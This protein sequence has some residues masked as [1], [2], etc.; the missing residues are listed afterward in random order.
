MAQSSWQPL[1]IGNVVTTAFQLYKNR[2]QPYFALAFKAYFWLLVPV[3]GWAKFLAIS[4]LI[5]RLVYGELVNQPETITG[6]TKY[7]NSKLWQFLIASVLF[8]LIVLS[9]WIALVIVSVIILTIVFLVIMGSVSSLQP[10]NITNTIIVA[11][12]FSISTIGS[13][14]FLIR[15]FVL[16]LPLAIEDNINATST[17]RRSWKLIKNFESHTL[18]ISLVAFLIT[19]PLLALLEIICYLIFRF[20]F[21]SW[22]IANPLIAL[23]ALVE[24]IRKMFQLLFDGSTNQKQIFNLLFWILSLCLGV[25]VGAM[26]LPFWQAVKAVVYYDLRTRKEGLGL[27]LRDRNV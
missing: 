15:L 19:L 11:I 6:G 26:Q 27:K 24:I 5:S 17:I 4:A 20:S 7:V 22:V 9:V 14:L 3:Y 25:V 13:L 12:A 21:G 1:S 18:L 10:G 23:I 2:F 8:T 16:E